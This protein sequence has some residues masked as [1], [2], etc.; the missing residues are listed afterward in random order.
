MAHKTRK[1]SQKLETPI[2]F[3]FRCRYLHFRNYRKLI[4]N[5]DNCIYYSKTPKD[6][7]LGKIVLK[8]AYLQ[9]DPSNNGLKSIFY[10]NTTTGRYVYICW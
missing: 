9:K 7:F 2:F 1:C 4:L 5:L 6:R 3:T 10:I 8:G